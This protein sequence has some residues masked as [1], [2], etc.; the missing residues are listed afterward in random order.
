MVHLW[1]QCLYFKSDKFVCTTISKMCWNIKTMQKK[2]KND[3]KKTEACYSKK[4]FLSSLLKFIYSFRY[5]FYDGQ[6][7]VLCR[8]KWKYILIL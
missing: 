1:Q 7:H 6:Q 4:T 8:I 2:K 3:K 5:N